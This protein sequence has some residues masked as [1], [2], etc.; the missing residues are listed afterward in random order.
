MGS[1]PRRVGDG[2]LRQDVDGGCGGG[3]R[4]RQ[5]L[6]LLLQGRQGTPL[7]QLDRGAHEYTGSSDY[8]QEQGHRDWLFNKRE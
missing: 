6:L 4:R 1:T 7:P 2:V 5:V 8:S 3:R